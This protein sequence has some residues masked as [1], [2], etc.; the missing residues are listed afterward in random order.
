MQTPLRKIRQLR[1][2]SLKNVARAVSSDTG[3]LSRIETGEQIAK[4]DL[5]ARL[6]AY[7]SPDINELHVIYPERYQDWIAVPTVAEK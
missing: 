6:A 2:L 1:G 7:F 5:A 4:R 3:N